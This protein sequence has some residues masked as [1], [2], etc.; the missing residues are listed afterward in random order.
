M[1]FYNDIIGPHQAGFMK[2]KSTVDN[3]FLLR[4]MGEKYWEFDKTIWHVFVDFS[5]AYDSVHRHSLWNILTEFRVPR[6]LIQLIRACYT[7]TQGKVRV[8]R[9]L[10]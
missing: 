3:I 5:Q 2:D 7:N 10:S 6:K 1:P 4:Q 9:C 8:G